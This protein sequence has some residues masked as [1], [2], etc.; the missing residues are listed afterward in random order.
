MSH[1][2]T[3]REKKECLET[4]SHLDQSADMQVLKPGFLLDRCI[5]L[6][7]AFVCYMYVHMLH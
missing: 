5:H 1:V 3:G 7:S 4:E 2:S 6:I